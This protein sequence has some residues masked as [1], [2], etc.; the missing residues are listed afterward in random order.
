MRKCEQAMLN[1]E[2]EAIH[3]TQQKYWLSLM[4]SMCVTCLLPDPVK[5]PGKRHMEHQH[6]SLFTTNTY[7]HIMESLQDQG[8]ATNGTTLYRDDK[9][10]PSSI[11]IH[12]QESGSRTI[13]SNNE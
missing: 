11:I 4:I 8:I 6:H 1:K 9:M 5:H 3:A 13:I 12:N 10:L 7:S 2:Q